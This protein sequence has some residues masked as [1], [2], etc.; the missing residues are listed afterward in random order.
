M[1]AYPQAGGRHR[2]TSHGF[3]VVDLETSGFDPAHSRIV[4]FAVVRIDVDGRPTG[5]LET[6]VDPGDADVGPTAVHGIHPAMLAGAPTFAEMAPTLLAWLEGVVVVAHHAPFED[7]FLT[8]EFARAG[9][10]V[11]LLPALDTLTM[12]QENLDLPNHKLQTVCSWAGVQIDGAHTALGDARATAAMLPHLLSRVG[13]A[14]Q[15]DVPMPRLA[16]HVRGR[17]QPRGLI[18]NH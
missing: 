17:Y 14:P 18:S 12:S 5:V 2:H 16:G 10:R 6:L 8:A 1:F 15:W 7:G 13:T 11:P 4:E 3:A 9:M